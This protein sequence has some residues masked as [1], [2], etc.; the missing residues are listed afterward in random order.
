M[1][2]TNLLL[3]LSAI[4]LF[5]ACSDNDNNNDDPVNLPA[6]EFTVTIENSMT[7]FD[8][9]AFGGTDLITPGNEQVITF[10]A[11]QGHYLNL[12]TMFVQSNDLFYAPADDG[13]ALYNDEGEALTGDITNQFY[14]WDAGTEVNEMPGTGENQAPRQSG[15]NTGTEE[16]GIV[17]LISDVNDGYT[18]PALNDVIE[19]MLSHDGGTQFT[20]TLRNISDNSSLPTPLAPGNWVVHYDGQYPLFQEGVAASS[21][22]EPIAEDGDITSMNEVLEATT[23]LVSP[24]APG[25]FSI[26]ESNNLFSIGSM[27]SQAFEMLA[28]DGDVSGF[29]NVFNTPASTDAPAPIFPGQSYTFTFTA[30]ENDRLSFATMLVQSNDWVLAID[31]LPLFDGNTPL[32][33]NLSDYIQLLDAGTESDQY[34]GAGMYQAPRQSGADQGPSE[35]GIINV[36]ESLSSNVPE[37][38]SML[39]ISIQVTE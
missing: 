8:Y 9:Y 19:V 39:N 27:A 34:A 31:Q 26:G 10:N 23:G 37:I 30:S 35:E 5:I 4:P 13:I 6:T 33:G 15:P 20:L 21:S 12:A 2:F 22:L 16:N 24:F 29:E 28:E 36:E 14:L 38:S 18:Y 7:P 1:K 11:G 17:R 25:A 32:S 3:S